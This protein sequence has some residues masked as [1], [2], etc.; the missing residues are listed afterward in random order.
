MAE[1][2]WIK[3]KT[4]MFDDE[5]I[6][7]IQSM[8]EADAVIVIWIRLLVL[9]GKT[10]DDGL[11]YIQRNMPYSD[12]MLST[13]FN[14]PVNV[15][16]LALKAL[17]KFGMIDLNEDGLIEIHNWEKHQNVSGMDKIRE[18][19]AKRSKTY[20]ERKRQKALG[21]VEDGKNDEKTVVTSRVT[22]RHATEEDIDKEED[23]EYIN[24]LSGKPAEQEKI[25]YSEI[26]EYL[27]QKTGKRYKASSAANKKLIKARFGEKATLDDFKIVVDNMVTNWTGTE[28]EKYLQP[29]TLFSNKFDKY[30]NQTPTQAPKKDAGRYGGLF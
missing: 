15:I 30:L 1:I 29:S 2:T 23:K 14:K 3:L 22:S 9:A 28:Y 4:T 27:N 25:P 13:L 6:R 18:D 8:P 10:N 21:H 17:E 16:R 26:I 12:E 5:K 24:P 19:S 11:I 7:L 20:R